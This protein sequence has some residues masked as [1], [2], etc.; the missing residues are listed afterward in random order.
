MMRPTVFLLVVAS[1]FCGAQAGTVTT[2]AGNGNKGFSG[3]GG[4]AT[5]AQINNVFAVACGPDGAL[6]LCDMDNHRIR[7]VTA[8][9]TIATYV[10]GEKRGYGGDGGPATAAQLN[11]EAFGCSADIAE[12]IAEG[13]AACAAHT[14]YDFGAAASLLDEFNNSGD[15][16]A[17]TFEFGAANPKFCSA[18]PKRR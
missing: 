8:D 18:A 14:D 10:G 3:D 15:A 17:A 13:N 16:L 4:P 12:V 2:V 9:G 6:Y 11:C 7:R 5:A 1:S